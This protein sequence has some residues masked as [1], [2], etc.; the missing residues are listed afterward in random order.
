[1]DAPEAALPRPLDRGLA[2]RLELLVSTG[3]ISALTAEAAARVTGWFEELLELDLDESN[4]SACVTHVAMALERAT[5]GDELDPVDVPE[6]DL[7]AMARP[8]ELADRIAERL[9][10][11]GWLLPGYERTMIALHLAVLASRGRRVP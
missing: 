2:A 5:R 4:A 1:M 3:V 7:A 11:D 10:A 6:Q 9:S 8:L